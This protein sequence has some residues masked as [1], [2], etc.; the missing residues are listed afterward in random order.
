MGD[1]HGA[2]KLEKYLRIH[3]G[4]MR[5]WV[6]SGFVLVDGVEFSGFGKGLYTLIGVIECAGGIDL[7]VRKLLAVVDGEGGNER[8]QTVWYSYNA[9]LRGRGNILRYDCP[10]DHREADHV[11]RFDVFDGD[12]D[13]RVENL[14]PREW[15]TI[16]QVLEE[17]EAWYREHHNKL[18]H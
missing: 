8:V 13:G 2:T 1:R 11:H 15:P 9:K 6:A 3:E 14:P 10:D 18:P 12:D 7:E 5:G 17:L 16:D 4:H